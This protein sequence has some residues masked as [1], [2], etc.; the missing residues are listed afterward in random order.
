MKSLRSAAI[1]V[2]AS[3]LAG[4]AAASLI[5]DTITASGLA[6]S[7][8]TATIGAGPE[9][10]FVGLECFD[11]DAS[12]LTIGL[13]PGKSGG[14]AWGDFGFFTFSG[15]DTEITGLTLASNTG[16]TGDPLSG[17]S[18]TSSSITL[19]WGVGSRTSEDAQLVFNI[20]TASVPEPGTTGLAGLA[21]ALAGLA[22]AR[23]YRK[24]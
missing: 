12:T 15:F 2:F 8:S 20:T 24:R 17:F 23:R 14:H 9:F 4:Q 3:V 10:N 7:P 13:C 22:A 1:A 6:L 19:H 11:F 21:V 16:Y 18:F 5:G